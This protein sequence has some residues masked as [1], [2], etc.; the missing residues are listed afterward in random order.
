MI[1]TIDPENNISAFAAAKD[2]ENPEAKQ[3]KSVKELN[4]LAAD[5]R[6]YAIR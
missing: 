1:F 3:F 2:I 6:A 4:K 5:W